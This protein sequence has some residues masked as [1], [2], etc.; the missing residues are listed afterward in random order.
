MDPFEAQLP[1]S[2]QMDFL[3]GL[4]KVE[5]VQGQHLIFVYWEGLAE[6]R[7]TLV[8]CNRRLQSQRVKTEFAT[9][10]KITILF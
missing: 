1:V 2:A 5:L 8:Q 4:F 6:L 9:S 3:H 7:S 10:T